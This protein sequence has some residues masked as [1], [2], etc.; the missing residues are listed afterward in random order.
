MTVRFSAMTLTEHSVSTSS[1]LAPRTPI[2]Y[3]ATATSV[4][5][6]VH[7]L[8]IAQSVLD[9]VYQNLPKDRPVTVRAVRLRIGAMGG[10]VP[11]SLDF[12]FSA[13]THGT[14]L[15]GALL[16]ID[17]VPLVVHCDSCGRDS[18]I[19]QTR[20]ACP[21]CGAIDLRVVTGNEMQ[22]REIE[23]E[24]DGARP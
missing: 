24:D 15:E 23:I 5:A 2:Q 13:L 16:E 9:I 3:I 6:S 7:E 10:V 19:E 21:A 14:P 18:E 4:C 20:F 17:H 12:C 8:S 1:Q 11:D 22:I